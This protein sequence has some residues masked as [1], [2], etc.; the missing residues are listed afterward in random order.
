VATAAKKYD[1]MNI[2]WTKVHAGDE[3]ET[4]RAMKSVSNFTCSVE[5]AVMGSDFRSFA[6]A[7]MVWLT[8]ASSDGGNQ[9]FGFLRFRNRGFR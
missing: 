6:A 8:R 3:L 7:F 5:I 2:D 9:P 4:Q 1:D